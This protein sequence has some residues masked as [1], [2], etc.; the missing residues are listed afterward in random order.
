MPLRPKH[1]PERTCVACR[2]ARPEQAK[3]P[4]R[5]LVRLVRSSDGRVSVDPTGKKPGRGA[6]LCDNPD[7]WQTGLRRGALERAL[8]TTLG[9]EDRAALERFAL[10][11]SEA[12]AQ[13]RRPQT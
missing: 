4:K 3:Q 7:C 12:L 10:T 5:E 13:D 2:S 6:Y 9:E 1:I 8:K 11:F